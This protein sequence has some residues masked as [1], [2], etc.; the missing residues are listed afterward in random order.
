MLV[1]TVQVTACAADKRARC[2]GAAVA[3]RRAAGG[4]ADCARATLEM[5]TCGLAIEG[6]CARR[7]SAYGR[8]LLASDESADR[9][10][11][12]KHRS[13]AR[14][15][16]ELRMMTTVSLRVSADRERRQ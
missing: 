2:R 5:L 6:V 12:K 10:A 9:S 13:R 3:D 16:P 4:R 15:T 14:L 8:A 1:P 7:A 11:T